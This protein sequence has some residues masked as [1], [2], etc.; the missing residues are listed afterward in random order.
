MMNE[1]RRRALR[2]QQER[3]RK[4]KRYRE[5]REKAHR[6]EQLLSVIGV[7][8]VVV[9]IG[10]LL[11]AAVGAADRATEAQAAT[12]IWTRKETLPVWELPPE[13]IEAEAEVAPVQPAEEIL[14][15]DPVPELPAVDRE[16]LY[17]MAHLLAGECQG[18]SW[19]LQTAV[20]SVVLNRVNHK[21]FPD[22][23]KEVVFQ[24]HPGIQY[25][26]T[27]D[28][29][30]DREPTERNWEVAEY[31]LRYGS[32]IP[33]NVIFQSQRPLGPI[34]GKIE[35]EYFCIEEKEKY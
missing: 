2:M 35:N 21:A 31:L 1:N 12:V 23:I 27:I 5:R 28:G 33:A 4:L 10:L 17:V 15:A 3:Q 24:R 16:E 26:C 8:A 11:M 7:V 18:G 6:R 34:W 13:G 20:G 14:F 30:Y 19:E 9:V 25:Q 32:Q 29:N 22:T